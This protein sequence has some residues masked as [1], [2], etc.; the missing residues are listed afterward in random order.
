MTSL[1]ELL[2]ASAA[3]HR[4]LCP[5]QVLGVRMG[6]LAGRLLGLE[7]PQASQC[8]L[9][10]GET[11][12]CFADGISIATGC[13]IGRRTLRV[14]DLGRIAA[15]FVDTRTGRAVRIAPSSAARRL[16]AD[17]APE[18]GDR[19]EAYLVGYQRMPDVLLFDWQRVKLTA[20]VESI[21]GHASRRAVCRICREEIINGREV[22]REG[23]VLCR[24]CAG[25]TYY[26]VLEAAESGKAKLCVTRQSV[27]SVTTC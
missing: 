14:E 6:I 4:H 25:P 18:A 17:F 15:T 12:G 1:A 9:T 3:R 7:L 8:L 26:T 13:W 10:I 5:R 24:A 23:S 2:E 22:H 11:D 16:S 21:L 19:W 27:H 20:P